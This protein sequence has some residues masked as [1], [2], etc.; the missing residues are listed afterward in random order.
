MIT[1]ANKRN[2]AK[3]SFGILVLRLTKPVVARLI[4]CQKVQLVGTLEWVNPI[5]R[6]GENLKSQNI[7]VTM[8]FK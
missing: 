1:E 5:S 6:S 4:T 8:W 7:S 2:E 3:N